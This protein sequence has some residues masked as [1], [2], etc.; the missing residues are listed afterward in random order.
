MVTRPD[1]RQPVA[2]TRHDSRTGVPAPAAT[3]LPAATTNAQG[4]FAFQGLDEGACTILVAADGH[5]PAAA[6]QVRLAAGQ[7]M[8]DVLVRLKPAAMVSG[9]IRDSQGARWLFG[10]C[11]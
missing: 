4:R 6:L 7:T 2:G 11:Q 3:P 8:R 5:V 1:G 9:R 10:T